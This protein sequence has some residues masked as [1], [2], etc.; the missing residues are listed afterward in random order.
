[1]L[2]N[3]TIHFLKAY[4]ILLIKGEMEDSKPLVIA[5]EAGSG[6]INDARFFPCRSSVADGT[7]HSATP[8][9]EAFSRRTTTAEPPAAAGAEWPAHVASFGVVAIA[10][11]CR[12]HRIHRNARLNPLTYS[13]RKQEISH[14]SATTAAKRRRQSIDTD[15]VRT[16]AERKNMSN[17]RFYADRQSNLS[18]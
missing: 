3:K 17:L 15:S 18:A 8:E 10:T 16:D 1:M 5:L 6:L 7:P 2:E 9:A 13:K 11:D 4:F 14:T 12:V